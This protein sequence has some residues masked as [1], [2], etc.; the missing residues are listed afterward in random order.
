MRRRTRSWARFPFCSCSR[1][2]S[3]TPASSPSGSPS[4]SRRSGQVPRREKHSPS[5]AERELSGLPERLLPVI[6]SF[7]G[8]MR[9]DLVFFLSGLAFGVAAGYFTFRAVAPSSAAR[10]VSGAES[11]AMP[12]STIGLDEK[13]QV[14][15]IDA[16]E[17]RALEAQARENGQDA[18]VRTKIGTL[19]MEAGRYEDARKWLEEAVRLDPADLHA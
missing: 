4:S 18:A 10:P 13:P 9:R 15:D 7:A 12:A 14:R 5:R 11:K 17:V 16:E 3:S 2:G 8:T 1:R 19:Y 6:D